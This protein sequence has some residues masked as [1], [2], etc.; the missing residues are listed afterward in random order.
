MQNHHPSIED[1]LNLQKL[2][3][4]M[5]NELENKKGVYGEDKLQIL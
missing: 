3:L 5:R 1:D 2:V 4:A